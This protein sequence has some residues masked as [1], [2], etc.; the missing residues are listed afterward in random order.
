MWQ[1][2]PTLVDDRHPLSQS[3]LGN[4]WPGI[5]CWLLPVSASS[6]QVISSVRSWVATSRVCWVGRL[7]A[8]DLRPPP[9]AF[10]PWGT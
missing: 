3:L 8:R 9:Q 1:N 4:E 6:R 10:H 5:F 2:I 7:V